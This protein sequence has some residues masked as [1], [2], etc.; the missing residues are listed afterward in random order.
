MKT[1]LVIGATGFLGKELVMQL[2]ASREWHVIV[3]ARSDT[4]LFR[5]QDTQPEVV[6]GHVSHA[7]LEDIRRRHGT[8][9]GIFLTA[10]LVKHTTESRAVAEMREANVAI[11]NI[12]FDFATQHKIRTVYASSS[13]VVGCQFLR[14]WKEVAE[15]DDYLASQAYRGLPY[16]EQKA[17]VES[18]WLPKAKAGLAP[19]IFLR[20][21]LLLGPGDDRL[22]ST[23]VVRDVIDQRLPFLVPGGVSAVDVR[24]VASAFIAAMTNDVDCVYGSAYNLTAANLSFSE[25]VAL[26]GKTAHV[27]YPCIKVPA[28]A[29][30]IGA[31]LLT[32]GNKVL[33]RPADPS[34]DPVFAEMGLRWWNVRSSAAKDHL[35]FAPRSLEVTVANTVA[36]IRQHQ[37]GLRSAEELQRARRR[38][39]MVLGI[40]AVIFFVLVYISVSR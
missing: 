25:F 21:S 4:Q 14:Q 39:W 11:P 30:R 19:I 7:A 18:A 35:G 33:R 1:V 38:R 24:D 34:V 9:D 6:V 5:N 12:V 3:L 22:S 8:L 26:I 28:F 17:L 37:V 27:S 32:A 23:T 31:R 20:P 15:D 13:G 29:S 16:Y 40:I 36:Y 10:G 2:L